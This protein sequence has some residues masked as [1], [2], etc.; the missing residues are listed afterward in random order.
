MQGFDGRVF[1][2]DFTV[3]GTADIL[4]GLGE[5]RRATTPAV[6]CLRVKSAAGDA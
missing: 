6:S 5:R 3:S 1:A 4:A 2:P